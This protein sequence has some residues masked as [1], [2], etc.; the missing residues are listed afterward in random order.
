MSDESGLIKKRT[1]T[2]LR[3]VYDHAIQVIDLMETYRDQLSGLT[4]LYLSSLSQ[5][6]NEVMQVLTIIGSIFIPLTFIAG[7]YGM[8]FA[9]MPE[10]QW[11]YGYPMVWGVMLL[12]AFGLFLYFRKRKWL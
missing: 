8:N 10:L 2:Y 11:K 3:D 6:M 9:S 7:I 4:D 1:T 5:R 12:T